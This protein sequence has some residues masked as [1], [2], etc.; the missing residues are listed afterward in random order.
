MLCQNPSGI[1]AVTLGGKSD[2]KLFGQSGVVYGKPGCD[3]FH[4]I[5]NCRR[6]GGVH[7]VFAKHDITCNIRDDLLVRSMTCMKCF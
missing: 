6:G 2:L 5:R 4:N 7:V 3:S 1:T